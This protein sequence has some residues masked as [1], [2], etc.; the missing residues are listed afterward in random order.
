MLAESRSLGNEPKRNIWQAV[1]VSS[2]WQSQGRRELNVLHR[3]ED[4]DFTAKASR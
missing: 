2:E 1:N 4:A 3:T